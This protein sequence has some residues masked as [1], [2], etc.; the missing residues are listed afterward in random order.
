MDVIV[1]MVIGWIIFSFLAEIFFW[2]VSHNKSVVARWVVGI[3]ASM[4]GTAT[5]GYMIVKANQATQVSCDD[6]YCK[7]EQ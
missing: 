6:P 4:V 2:L 3:L 1:V 5:I 7:K